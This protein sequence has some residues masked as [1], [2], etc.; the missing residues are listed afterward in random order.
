M[1]FIN[2]SQITK[3]FINIDKINM[4]NIY[5]YLIPMMNNKDKEGI[6]IQKQIKDIEEKRKEL[7]NDKRKVEKLSKIFLKKKSQLMPLDM[8]SHSISNA[9]ERTNV[10]SEPTKFE[11]D[12]TE[13]YNY[14][15][16]IYLSTI[17]STGQRIYKFGKTHDVMNRFRQYP[18]DSTVIFLCRVADCHH[19]EDEIYE[20]FMKYFDKME[21]GREYF[22]TLNVE[23]MINCMNQLIDHMHQRVKD[24]NIKKIMNS[25]KNVINFRIDGKSTNNLGNEL[26]QYYAN[27]KN[28]DISEDKKRIIRKN[29]RCTPNKTSGK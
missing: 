14:I 23:S 26:I 22:M 4:I 6:W 3:I 2:T 1:I 9:S 28:D 11:F 20:S 19:V 29:V 18:K 27:N 15:Y 13:R 7:D 10:L 5:H 17:G 25:Y 24:D 12:V 21:N 16:L 8:E